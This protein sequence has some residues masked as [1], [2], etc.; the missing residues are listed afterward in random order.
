[1]PRYGLLDYAAILIA[2][3]AHVPPVYHVALALC[4]MAFWYRDVREGAYRRWKE[5]FEAEA[6]NHPE[7]ADLLGALQRAETFVTGSGVRLDDLAPARPLPALARDEAQNA[8][9]V[10]VVELANALL[11]REEI[12]EEARQALRDALMVLVVLDMIE[13]SGGAITAFPAY[14]RSAAYQSAYANPFDSIYVYQTARLIYDEIHREA[15]AREP[16]AA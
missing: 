8:N 4:R 2:G 9:A 13:F 7:S 5:V 10:A 3:R 6:P 16:A 14:V 11:L 1:M 12:G 15:S